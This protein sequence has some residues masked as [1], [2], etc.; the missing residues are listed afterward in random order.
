M[1]R[2]DGGAAAGE[3]SLAMRLARLGEE[4][5]RQLWRALGPAG[6]ARLLHDWRFWG[7]PS[8][9]PP[10]GNWRTW[11][12]LAGRGFGK[13]RAGAEWVRMLATGGGAIGLS[14]RCH[15]RQSA[16]EESAGEKGAGG[17]NA[18]ER[19][20]GGK[21][22]TARAGPGVAG[23]GEEAARD[24]RGACSGSKCHLRHFAEGS[25]GAQEWEQGWEREH[26]QERI[27]ADWAGAGWAG[28]DLAGEG[29]AGEGCT[30]KD[31]IGEGRAGQDCAGGNCAGGNC[32]SGLGV[33]REAE[34]AG[35]RTVAAEGTGVL[36]GAQQGR[37]RPAGGPVRIGL[38]AATLAEA[39]A[40]MVEGESGLLAIAPPQERPTFEPALRRL[41]WPNGSM[42]TLYS[43][44]APEQLR[45]AQHHFAWCD[46][47]AKWRN[48]EAVWANLQMGLRLGASPRVMVTTTPR[49]RPLVRA[50]LSNPTVAV[51]RGAT[52]DNQA[53]LPKSFLAAMVSAYGGTRLGRQ[54]LDGELVEAVEG[55]LW[56]PDMIER[57]R[58]DAAPALTRVV[59]AVDPPVTGGPEADACGIVVAGLG[60]DGLAY[61]LADRSLH[62][63]SPEGWA[64]AVAAAAD[65]FNADRVVAEANNGG[66]LVG[67]VL[68]SVSPQ[69]P[70]K[71]VRASRGKSARA[72]PVAA[73]YE[74]G[75]VRHAGSFAKLEDELCG[76]MPG[77]GYVGPSRSPDRADALVWALT[78]LMLGQDTKPRIRT[79]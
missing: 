10:A 25:G 19:G 75:R 51:T 71:L 35:L 1:N 54:E 78:E 66:D 68:R 42:A 29:R 76:L 72:E 12:V 50:L 36:P 8:Q 52:W 2:Q 48:A 21:G 38:V 18:G 56:S 44:D 67:L 13:T 23:A 30:W 62:G 11:L 53:N 6:V 22:G 28:G 15:V 70:V 40:V 64:R 24:A 61:V 73:L 47:L 26:E 79:L 49:P 77:G 4:E 46:E 34:G 55:A 39:R 33:G 27:G 41:V 63:A 16:D 59:V 32:A 17:E 37:H 69:L 7:R 5:R 58:I 14:T 60:T 43:A 45:G 65:E 9:L 3:A 20:A 74:Q 57:S 31:R